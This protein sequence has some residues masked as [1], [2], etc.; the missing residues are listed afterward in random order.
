MICERC[1]SRS[2]AR[3][4]DELICLMC[5]HRQGDEPVRPASA[6]KTSEQQPHNETK[7][8]QTS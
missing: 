3:N 1:G 2:V 6:A 5:R 7:L 8:S 4:Y